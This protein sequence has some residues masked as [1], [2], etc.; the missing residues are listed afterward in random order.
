MSLDSFKAFAFNLDYASFSFL[1]L[2][3]RFK[4]KIQDDCEYIKQFCTGKLLGPCLF[5]LLVFEMEFL[6]TQTT[7]KSTRVLLLT[8][9]PDGFPLTEWVQG[10][11]LGSD[12]L[13]L[14]NF[15]LLGRPKW[16]CFLKKNYRCG[17]I[18]GHKMLPV[19]HNTM[20]AHG[21]FQSEQLHSLPVTLLDAQG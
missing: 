18:A 13:F 8:L 7:F 1:I 11:G 10:L 16:K 14:K 19:F 12:P 20:T 2:V 4:Q 9:T 17:L 3:C 6:S 5:C 21:V 15:F